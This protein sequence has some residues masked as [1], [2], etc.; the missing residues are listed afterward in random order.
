MLPPTSGMTAALEILA[1]LARHSQE[2]ALNIACLPNLLDIIVK[3]CIPISMN[4]PSTIAHDYKKIFY[5]F[6]LLQH[7]IFPVQ[8]S[9]EPNKC[10]LVAAVRLCRIL[11]IYAGRPVVERLKNL[12]IIHSLLA[13]ISSDARY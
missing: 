3:R 6:F 5:D 2:T 11:I 1:R 13:Y 4:Q 9:D 8:N 10:P 7:F 12:Q